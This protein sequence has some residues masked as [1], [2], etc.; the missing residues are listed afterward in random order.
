ME[1]TKYKIIYGEAEFNCTYELLH[2]KSLSIYNTYA[3]REA[4]TVQQ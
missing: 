1:L 2:S 3:P 4:S